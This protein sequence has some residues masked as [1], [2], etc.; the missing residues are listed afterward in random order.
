M[1]DARDERGLSLAGEVRKAGVACFR[2]SLGEKPAVVIPDPG[3][4]L[5]SLGRPE[6]VAVPVVIEAGFPSCRVNHGH[7]LPEEVGE[8]R[9]GA[10][11][12][13]LESG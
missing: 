8:Q 10:T 5:I 12:G 4:D 6:K 1:A 13:I 9:M 2:V 3:P 7:L 11:F